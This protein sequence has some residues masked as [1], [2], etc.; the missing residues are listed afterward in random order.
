MK[1][2]ILTLFLTLVG[3]AG[4]PPYIPPSGPIPTASIKFTQQSNATLGSMTIF[5]YFPD[6]PKSCKKIADYQRIGVID[7][8]NPFVESTDLS[9]VLVEANKPFTFVSGITPA[10]AFSQSS[11]NKVVSFVPKKG[12]K[13]I[14]VATYKSNECSVSITESNINKAIDFDFVYSC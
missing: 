9:N 10:N 2:V 12:H 6:S 8:G 11:C 3:C 7:K 13:Y 14:V 4:F 5:N 1:L